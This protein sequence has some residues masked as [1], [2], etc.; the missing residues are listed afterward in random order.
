[1]SA[2]FETRITNNAN[3]IT[4]E[5]QNRENAITAL[6]STVA[7][8]YLSASTFKTLSNDIGLSAASKTNPVVTKSDIAD[9]AGA[10]HFVGAA[11]LSAAD[12]DAKACLVRTFADAKKGDVAIIV[13]TSKEYVY[14]SDTTG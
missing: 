6:S 1:M 12:E 13:S 11:T 9:L 7:S 4:A 10:M 3:A 8:T 5:V 2:D 14:V